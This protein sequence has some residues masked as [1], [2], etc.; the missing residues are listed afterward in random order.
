M[1][2]IHSI[3]LTHINDRPSF[4]GLLK[5]L[6]PYPAAKRS[7]WTPFSQKMGLKTAKEQKVTVRRPKDSPFW[8][9]MT[10]KGVKIGPP[11]GNPGPGP[12]F[13]PSQTPSFL[14]RL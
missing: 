3:F 9:K 8:S 7:S 6:L 2:L 11:G 12:L 13:G 5:Q 4:F 10:K 14:K 1:V